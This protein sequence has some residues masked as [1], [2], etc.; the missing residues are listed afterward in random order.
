MFDVILLVVITLV[1]GV[2]NGATAMGFAIL[3]AVGL[4]LVVDA[5][6]AVLLLA[7]TNPFVS[8]LQLSRHRAAAS[9]GLRRTARLGVGGI[10]GVPVGAVLLGLV[11]ERIVALL[12]AIVTAAFIVNS[13]RRQRIHVS[14]RAEPYLSPLVGVVAGIANGALGVSGP[15]LGS[16]LLSLNLA[17]S[18]FAFTISGLFFAMGVVRL[19]SLFAL[20][21]LNITLVLTGAALLVPALVGQGIGFRLQA[22]IPRETFRR[23]VLIALTIAAAALFVRALDP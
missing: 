3:T 16:Y 1:A 12:L 9:D 5:K 6:M 14:P 4:S 21:Q 2:L 8:G 15:V 18:A 19:V 17:A 20:G 13:L 11:D 10:I 22:V 23:A 7:I